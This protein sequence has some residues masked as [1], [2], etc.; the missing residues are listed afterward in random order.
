MTWNNK[1][2]LR[3]QCLII[4]C[5]Q[6]K[7][8]GSKGPKCGSQWP[9]DN[10]LKLLFFSNICN[11]WRHSAIIVNDIPKVDIIEIDKKMKT[12]VI[13]NQVREISKI[14]NRTSPWEAAN[15]HWWLIWPK[16]LQCLH[17]HFC[18]LYVF[19]SQPENSF[20]YLNK[21]NEWFVEKNVHIKP[22]LQLLWKEMYKIFIDLSSNK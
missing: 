18:S 21:G 7:S 6:W 12:P 19:K 5:I 3:K 1:K 4:V 8:N 14:S 10:R 22:F 11:T 2:N 16:T 17:I 15:N 9:E 20:E 13:W